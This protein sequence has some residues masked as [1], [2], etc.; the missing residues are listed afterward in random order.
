[1]K[2]GMP[3]LVECNSFEENLKICADLNLDF[4]EINMNLPEFTSGMD[5]EQIQT[6][7]EKYN[8]FAT[9]HIGERIDIAEFDPIVRKAYLDHLKKV[10]DIAE[11]L[12][13]KR[14]NIH[15]SE[16]IH[17]KLPKEKVYLYHQYEDIYLERIDVFKTFVEEHYNGLVL[18]ENTGILNHTFIEKAINNLL[19]SPS[20][21]LT[22]DMG[23]DITS[24][25]K[26]LK[27]YKDNQQE[28]VHY[29]IHDGTALKNHLP[30]YQGELDIDAYM[31]L[32][33]KKA[34]Y[35]VIEVK[36]LEDLKYSVK[37][38]VEKGHL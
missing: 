37:K 14:L 6:L 1:M 30:L 2:L 32:I 5:V 16:G 24:G 7:L 21:A 29:H 17:F 33:Q 3:T 10:F 34:A 36:S 11:S 20:F 12:N 35:G 28:V 8:K 19:E 13:V 26:D 38:L 25:F 23:H 22:Y 4:V 27:F 31:T 15:M 18:L 9:L